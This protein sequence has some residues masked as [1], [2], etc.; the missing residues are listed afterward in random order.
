[1]CH[2]QNEWYPGFKVNLCLSLLLFTLKEEGAHTHRRILKPFSGRA[3]ECVLI[4]VCECVVTTQSQFRLLKWDFPF[5]S[6]LTLPP[7]FHLNFSC[8]SLHLFLRQKIIISQERQFPAPM[9]PHAVPV[10]S[11]W[12]TYIL[13]FFFFF[14]QFLISV[15]FS[16]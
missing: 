3:A 12:K 15:I 2:T 10:R 13:T 1:M 5:F 4:T 14:G 6:P 7:L 8:I 16:Y 9:V 11:F